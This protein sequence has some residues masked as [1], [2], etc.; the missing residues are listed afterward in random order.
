MVDRRKE[1]KKK[2]RKKMWK[3]VVLVASE[4]SAVCEQRRPIERRLIEDKFNVL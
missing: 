2:K 1:K 4:G 3:V